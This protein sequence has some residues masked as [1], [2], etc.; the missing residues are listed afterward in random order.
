MTEL[1]Y[2]GSGSKGR[3]QGVVSVDRDLVVHVGV[4]A[5]EDSVDPLL[6]LL[7]PLGGDEAADDQTAVGEEG[8]ADPGGRQ[9]GRRDGGNA[10][11]VGVAGQ[12]DGLRRDEVRAR[13]AELGERLVAEL[14]EPRLDLV[15][16]LLAVGGGEQLHGLERMPVGGE[17]LRLGEGAAGPAPQEPHRAAPAFRSRRRVS[18]VPSGSA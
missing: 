16:A 9:I 14:D 6:E 8:A 10:V 5:G 2:S 3:Y 11:V 4:A 13:V 7:R 18:S 12:L 17:L 15:G 1:T